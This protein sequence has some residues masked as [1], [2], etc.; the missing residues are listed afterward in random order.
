[1]KFWLV[2]FNFLLISYSAFALSNSEKYAIDINEKIPDVKALHKDF[3]K[4]NSNYNRHFSVRWDMPDKFDSQ[5]K[6]LYDTLAG[7]ERHLSS[8]SEDEIYKMLKIMPKEMYPYIGPYLHT[9]PQLSGRILDMP[10][11]KETKNKFPEQ[12]AER[13]KDIPNIEY[14]SPYLYIHLLPDELVANLEKTEYSPLTHPEYRNLKR[15]NIAPEIIKNVIARTPLDD[16]VGNRKKKSKGIR[17]YI[18]TEATNLSGAD[19]T[20]FTNTLSDLHDFNTKNQADLIT[21]AYIISDWE[22]QNGAEKGFY[23]YKQIANPCHSMVRNVKWNK[24]SLDFQKI[25]GKN[26]FGLDDW[27][28]ICEKTLK[29]YRRANLN[30][31][32]AIMLYGMKNN[33]LMRYYEVSGLNNHELQSLKN[34]LNAAVEMYNAPKKDVD[35][36]KFHMNKLYKTIPAQNSYFLG[37]PIVM[38]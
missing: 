6:N 13:F 9:M 34:I 7:D 5:F 25:I 28:I 18:A 16:Y 19:V 31:A 26:G 22:E 37:T 35:E 8:L 15:W 3:M 11:I 21:T 20:A 24:Q 2:L 12:I 27:A 17:H 10:G 1:M 36:V 4:K 33:E 30:T 29:A 23:L 32:T 14:A 38:P